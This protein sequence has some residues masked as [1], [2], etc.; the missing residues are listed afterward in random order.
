M[1]NLADC[2]ILM[3]LHTDTEIEPI[4]TLFDGKPH[5][6]RVLRTVEQCERRRKQVS[7]PK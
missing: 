4:E 1:N 5:L 7:E 3:K 2:Y 6:E